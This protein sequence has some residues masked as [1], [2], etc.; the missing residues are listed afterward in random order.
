MSAIAET[1]DIAADRKARFGSLERIVVK[2]GTRILTAQDNSLDVE[3][4]QD[5][6]TQMAQIRSRG[7]ELV[8]V[9]SG[10][11]GAGMGRLGLTK[12]PKSI[13]ELQACASV[14]QVQLMHHYKL[15]L[16]EHNIAVGQLLLTASDLRGSKDRYIHIQQ[17]FRGLEHAGVLPVVNEND[18]VAV[19][20]LRYGD[21]DQLSAHVANLIGADLMVVFTTADG[22]CDEN[23]ATNQH[24]QVIPT[25]SEITSEI[26]SLA[27]GTD[28]ENAIGGMDTKIKAAKMLMATG[29]M[30]LIA[31]GRRTTLPQLLDGE[32]SGTLFVPKVDRADGHK[33]YILA[34]SVEGTLNLDDGAANAIVGG[35][36]SLLP[37]GITNVVGKFTPGDVVSLKNGGDTG[38]ARG[39]TTYDAMD[40]RRIAG[41]QSSDITELLGY[42]GGDEAVHRDN[43]VLV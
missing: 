29:V 6:A 1:V 35:G 26:E 18:T 24:A 8:L 40:M 39:L 19:E 15:A 4:V 25:V 11:V 9:S 27:A 2:V 28:D 7:V 23:P 21:N 32:P 34:Q 17:A 3:Y 22:L 14:G 33:R 30:M 31:H 41:R 20:E 37:S 38:I 42:H 13:E 16:R 5:L 12:R 43:L 10:A 36:K